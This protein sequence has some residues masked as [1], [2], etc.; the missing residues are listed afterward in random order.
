MEKPLEI[1]ELGFCQLVAKKWGDNYMSFTKL[2]SEVGIHVDELRQ[3]VYEHK[4]PEIKGNSA[5]GKRRSTKGRIRLVTRIC[6]FFDLDLEACL[7]SCGLPFDAYETHRAHSQRVEVTVS[8]LEMLIAYMS[9]NFLRKLP[10][11]RIPMRILYLR[12]EAH[13]RENRQQETD[14]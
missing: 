12:D 8:D 5:I 6:D 11:S 2:A 9:Q 7:E 13:I 1:T 10:S 14:E 4:L 3:I